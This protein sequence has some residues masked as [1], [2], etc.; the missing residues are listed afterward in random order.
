MRCAGTA[1]SA[2][3]ARVPEVARVLRTDSSPLTEDEPVRRLFRRLGHAQ[4]AAAQRVE[5][6]PDRLPHGGDRSHLPE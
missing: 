3:L 6:R 4:E 5:R 1:T 2:S